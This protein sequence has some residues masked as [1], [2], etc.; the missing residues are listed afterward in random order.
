MG[1]T[2]SRTK[3]KLVLTAGCVFNLSILIF[4]KYCDFIVSGLNPFLTG[5]GL[6]PINFLSPHLPLGISFFTF[7]ALCYVVDVYR[8]DVPTQKKISHVA[9]YIAFFPQLIAGPIIRYR[10]VAAQIVRRVIGLE[11]LAIG[12]GRFI[13]G[14]GKKL[15]IADSLAVVVDKIFGLPPSEC[16]IITAFSESLTFALLR[17]SLNT[18]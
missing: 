8:R 14:L 10:D 3:R 7:Q 15:L 13:V 17:I 16:P 18:I 11:D 4:F 12:V 5:I 2:S 6:R 9:L 1:E